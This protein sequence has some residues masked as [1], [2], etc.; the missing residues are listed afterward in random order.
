MTEQV[1]NDSDGVAKKLLDVLIRQPF[2]VVAGSLVGAF[3]ML[4]L[5]DSL[6]LAYQKVPWALIPEWLR[7]ILMLFREATGFLYGWLTSFFNFTIPPVWR[8]Y[9]SMGFIV[10]GMRSRST[11]V[12]R[13][14]VMNG[15]IREYREE[16]FGRHLIVRKRSTARLWL[17]FFAWRLVF[18]F[19]LWPMKIFGA[20]YRYMTGKVRRRGHGPHEAKVREQQYLVFFGSMIWFIV[21]LL[22]ILIF[23]APG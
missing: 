18:A 17:T 13:R 11:M 8:D 4:N 21:F 2:P 6:V 15:H 9:L 5:F 14:A 12:I 16:I 19:G 23:N 1:T 22:A 20:S 3:G 10:A 7:S